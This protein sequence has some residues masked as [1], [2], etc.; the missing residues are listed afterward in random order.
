MS[1]THLTAGYSRVHPVLSITELPGFA[2]LN[3]ATTSLDLPKS[4]GSWACVTA[5]TWMVPEF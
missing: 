2:R 5:G 3:E 4:V 1:R